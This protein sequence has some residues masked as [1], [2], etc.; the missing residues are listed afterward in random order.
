MCALRV[1]LLCPV[2]LLYCV[3]AGFVWGRWNESFTE[4]LGRRC[5]WCR[6]T[7]RNTSRVVNLVTYVCYED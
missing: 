5:A 6:V 3:F 1:V 7:Q 2:A 4:A